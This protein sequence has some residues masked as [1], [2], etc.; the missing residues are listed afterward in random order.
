MNKFQS[1]EVRWAYRVIRDYFNGI[2]P[3][4]DMNDHM[5]GK[6][7]CFVSLHLP[8]DVLRGCIGTLEPV[9]KN[10]R[11]EIR[12]NALA[13]AFNDPRFPPLER[14]ELETLD[15]S[16]DV[17]G[18]VEPIASTKSLDPRIYG[19]IVSNGH[20]RGVLLPNL[21]GVDTVQQQVSIAMR[22]AGIAEGS[23]IKLERF[24]VTRYI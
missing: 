4:E 1:E 13:A 8:G 21:D 9:R 6:A 15:I 24:Q 16:V 19:V 3:N 17:L 12:W 20:K 18:K 22:K 23:P 7:A 11:E 14:R 2:V 5:N 10:L